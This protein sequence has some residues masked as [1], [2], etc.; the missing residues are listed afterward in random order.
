M[1][2]SDSFAYPPRGLS[3]DRS[4]AY[5]GV[6]PTKFD[7]MVEDGRMPKPKHIDGR[8]VWDRHQLDASFDALDDDNSDMVTK[9]KQ[10]WDEDEEQ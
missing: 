7:E 2:K 10:A 9:A 6:G 8:V 4:A 5:I 3:R 1:G